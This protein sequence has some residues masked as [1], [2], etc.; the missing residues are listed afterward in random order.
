MFYLHWHP[1]DTQRLLFDGH[2]APTALFG[3]QK[4]FCFV[5]DTVVRCPRLLTA[6]RLPTFL[7]SR[8]QRHSVAARRH[9]RRRRRRQ[10]LTGGELSVAIAQHEGG[11]GEPLIGYQSDYDSDRATALPREPE[12]EHHRRGNG[13]DDDVVASD[14]TVVLGRRTRCRRHQWTK[15]R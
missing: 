5:R 9:R 15:C 8:I 7:S 3:T 11:A 1:T 14:G 13:E 12:L 10:Q 6:T 4:T 2:C